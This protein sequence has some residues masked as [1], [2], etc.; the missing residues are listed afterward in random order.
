MPVTSVPLSP[1]A[2]QLMPSP[3]PEGGTV[4]TGTQDHEMVKY[5]GEG[6]SEDWYYLSGR[7]ISLTRVKKIM[8][9]IQQ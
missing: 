2:S 3:H 4:R 9:V 5:K 7:A 8:G 1:S 6:T